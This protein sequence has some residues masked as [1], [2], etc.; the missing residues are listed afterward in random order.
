MRR[1]DQSI[2]STGAT[3]AAQWILHNPGEEDEI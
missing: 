2:R 1:V 3:R